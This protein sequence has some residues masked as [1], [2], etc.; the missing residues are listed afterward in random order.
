M[1][2]GRC[3]D[4]LR[5]MRSTNPASKAKGLKGRGAPSYVHS[6]PDVEIGSWPSLE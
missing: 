3:A 1:V 2:Q 4:A 6:V 5:P